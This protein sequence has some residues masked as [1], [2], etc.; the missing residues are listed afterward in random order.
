MLNK[1]I[2]ATEFQTRAGAYIERAGKEPVFITKH[3]RPA[4]VLVDYDEYTR[5]KSFDTREYYDL[6]TDKL[7][8]DLL[9][10]LDKGYQGEENPQLDRLM[11]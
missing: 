10:E 8:D 6:R 3:N 7:P 4:R 1:T 9:E 5:L 11:D 2:T